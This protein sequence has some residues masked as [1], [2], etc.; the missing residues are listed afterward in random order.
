MQTFK[1]QKIAQTLLADLEALEKT[2]A[3]NDVS[4]SNRVVEAINRIQRMKRGAAILA[5]LQSK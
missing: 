5:R 1:T 2:L 3:S 4:F